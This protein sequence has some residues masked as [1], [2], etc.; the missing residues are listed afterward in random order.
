M[1]ESCGY[2]DIQ[3]NVLLQRNILTEDEEIELGF[4]S[5]CEIQLHIRDV[6]DL[7]S[8]AGHAPCR[9]P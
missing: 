7:K 5:T 8:D 1:A 2:R 9:I 6:Y 4:M 3:L